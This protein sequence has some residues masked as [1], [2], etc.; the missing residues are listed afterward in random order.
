MKTIPITKDYILIL[1]GQN[2]YSEFNLYAKEEVIEK[3]A[4]KMLEAFGPHRYIANLGHGLYP[5]TEKEKVKF[6]I[7]C[8]KRYTFKQYPAGKINA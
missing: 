7:D 1:P 8:V 4:K 2:L 6:F 5:D 3:E